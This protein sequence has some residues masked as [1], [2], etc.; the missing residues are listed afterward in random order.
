[1]LGHGHCIS[2][3]EI[4]GFCLAVNLQQVNLPPDKNEQRAC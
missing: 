2:S 1:L 4:V 3:G